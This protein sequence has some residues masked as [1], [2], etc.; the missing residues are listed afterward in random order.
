MLG[1]F[2]ASQQD[3]VLRIPTTVFVPGVRDDRE[4]PEPEPKP[5]LSGALHSH[6]F[7]QLG[8]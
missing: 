3:V 4:E 1:L 6:Y 8:P 2:F 5:T 7:K